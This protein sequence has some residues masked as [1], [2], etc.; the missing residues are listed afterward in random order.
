MRKSTAHIDDQAVAQAN[1]VLLKAQD[2]QQAP[3]RGLDLD[4]RALQASFPLSTPI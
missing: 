2:I 4:L 3:I 1:T